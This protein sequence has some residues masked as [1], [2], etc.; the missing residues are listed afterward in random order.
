MT[1]TT[2]LILRTLCVLHTVKKCVIFIS[3]DLIVV[4]EWLKLL[5]GMIVT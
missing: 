4:A 5:T 1:Q 3:P 2:G